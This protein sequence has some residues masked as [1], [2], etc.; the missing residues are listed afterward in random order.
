MSRTDMSGRRDRVYIRDTVHDIRVRGT[1]GVRGW[2][3]VKVGM[4]SDGTL[5]NNTASQGKT[6][7]TKEVQGQV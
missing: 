6:Y 7:E 2:C 1:L 4:D 3:R 5:T